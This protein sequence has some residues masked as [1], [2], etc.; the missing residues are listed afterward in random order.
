MDDIFGSADPDEFINLVRAFAM[1]NALHPPTEEDEE[2]RVKL[3]MVIAE[4][5]GPPSSFE[6]FRHG[7][8][9]RTRQM[10]DS[11]DGP[12]DDWPPLLDM[13]ADD[14]SVMIA[15]LGGYMSSEDEKNVLAALVIP[16]LLVMNNALQAALITSAWMAHGHK[17]DGLTRRASEH[18]SRKE[19]VFATIA[20]GT[21][22]E[23]W[24]ADIKRYRTKNPSLLPWKPFAQK[25]GR[26]EVSGRLL[27]PLIKT[28][29]FLQTRADD[30]KED[31]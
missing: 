19:V 22:W 10:R 25:G 1:K 7:V 23:M 2:A 12:E 4:P 30:P 17:G 29:E 11:L 9:D 3:A 24:C 21:E 26:M 16:G 5:A 28:L 20:D 15:H 14:G 6:Q 18:P 8:L 31:A 13:Q 27:D